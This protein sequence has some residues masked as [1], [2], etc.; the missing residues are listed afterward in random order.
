MN[1]KIFLTSNE[2][3]EVNTDSDGDDD[4][5]GKSVVIKANDVEYGDILTMMEKARE[6]KEFHEEDWVLDESREERNILVIY[7]DQGTERLECHLYGLTDMQKLKVKETLS[8]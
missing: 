2:E 7:V 4:A 8:L 6:L 3:T 5:D 1:C